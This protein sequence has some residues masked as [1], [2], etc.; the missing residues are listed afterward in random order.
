M[1]GIARIPWWQWNPFIA[2]RIVAFVEAADEVPHRLPAKGAVVVGS[3][4]RPKWL[5]FDCPCRTG[6]RIM[7][8]LDPLHSPHWTLLKGKPL[9]VS[10]SIDYQTAKKRCHYFIRRG[11]TIWTDDVIGDGYERTR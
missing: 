2:W 3:I 8:S 11:K 6:H 1:A 4:Q 10:P 7:V 5:A 9:S